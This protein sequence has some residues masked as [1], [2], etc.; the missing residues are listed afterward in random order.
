GTLRPF[1]APPVLMVARTWDWG[2]GFMLS[3]FGW[4]AALSIAIS[5]GIYF[6]LFKRQF[7]D[8][9]S[10]VPAFDAGQASAEIAVSDGTPHMPTW[11]T[12][13]H[14]MFMAWT[15]LTA[16]YP[17]LFIGGFLFFL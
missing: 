10:R 2:T 11:I 3:H 5:T 8:L 16:H 9:A 1:A 7:A 6:V 13:V 17:A 15:V 4:R 12:V 14:L